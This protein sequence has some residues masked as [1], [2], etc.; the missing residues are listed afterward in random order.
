MTVAALTPT[1]I[2][3]SLVLNT[4]SAFECKDLSPECE[5]WKANMK[6]NCK[7]ADLKYMVINCPKTCDLCEE[8][9]K[10]HAVLEEERK[11]NPTYEPEDSHV[12][13][14]TSETLDDYMEQNEESIIL[15][16]FY[17]PW[18]GGCQQVAPEFRDAAKMLAEATDLPFPVKFAKFDDSAPENADYQAGSPE[19]WNFTSYP[20]MFIIDQE[21]FND[22]YFG[23]KE[24]EAF[25][26][27]MTMI[28]QGKNQSEASIEWRKIERGAR[29]GFYKPGGLH[30]SDQVEELLPDIFRD[31][32]LRS[33]AVWLV[34]FYSDKCPL[35]KSLAPLIIESATR[36]QKDHP[37]KI[38]F[39]ALNGRVYNEVPDA[40]DV[41]SLPIVELLYMGVS[42]G[43]FNWNDYLA[44]LGKGDKLPGEERP[45]GADIY[46]NWGVQKMT[47]LWREDNG[48]NM[49]AEIPPISEE[50][51]KMLEKVLVKDEDVEKAEDPG[52]NEL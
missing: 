44:E 36:L 22:P 35:C 49:T 10:E 8:A 21:G 30:E 43:Q 20:S 29:P 2:L 4:A 16:E 17:A 18:C 24:A 23:G 7:G 6:G 52:E 40:Y 31:T 19:M 32:V 34:E 39:G 15:L 33:D 13:Q 42:H 26:H 28:A 51:Q 14:L 47:E 41:Q 25:V 48:A 45:S 9:E 37:G 11:K 38:R 1:L 46:Y 27:H 5:Q 50:D 3:V 12:I